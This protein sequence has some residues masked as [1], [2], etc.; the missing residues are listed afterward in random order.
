M[1]MRRTVWWMVFL[2]SCGV[3]M[4]FTFLAGVFCVAVHD[5][6]CTL[7]DHADFHTGAWRYLD[8]VDQQDAWAFCNTLWH[9]SAFMGNFLLFAL[10]SAC[11]LIVFLAGSLILAK[12]RTRV[13]NQAPEDTARKLADP[14]R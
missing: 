5:G 10:L 14:Q 8:K 13:P 2:V 6:L 1:N 3:F 11:A 4:L 7:L 12:R 9:Q